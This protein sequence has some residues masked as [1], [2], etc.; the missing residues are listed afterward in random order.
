M[1][2]ALMA[3]AGVAQASGTGS[4]KGTVTAIKG[5][6]PLE[7]VTVNSLGPA[8]NTSTTTNAEGEYTFPALAEGEYTVRVER[9]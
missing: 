2:L 7:G 5:G 1:A 6:A 4:I 8:T 9:I 3:G